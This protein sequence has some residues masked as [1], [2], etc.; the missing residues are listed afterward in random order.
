MALGALGGWEP[1]LLITL[2]AVGI[3]LWLAALRDIGKGNFKSSLSKW[4]WIAIV[5]LLPI[6]GALVY[7]FLGRRDST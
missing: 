5:I 7:I 2:L 4:Q 1:L 3:G 6:V